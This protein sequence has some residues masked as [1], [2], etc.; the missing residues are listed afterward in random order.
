MPG[1]LSLDPSRGVRLASSSAVQ[2]KAGV[3]GTAAGV[4]CDT[5]LLGVYI[6]LTAVTA[7]TLTIAGLSDSAG[8]AASL[9]ISGQIPTDTYWVPHEPLLNY[10]GPFVF[11]ASAANI[12]WLFLRAYNGPEAPNAGGYAIR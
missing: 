1:F 3:L 10:F 2:C 11:T 4:A 12:V 6:P 5:L 7:T 9:L 8:A